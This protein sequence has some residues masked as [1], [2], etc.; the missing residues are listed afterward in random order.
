MTLFFPDLSSYEGGVVLQPGTPAVI[1]KATEGNYYVD[2]YFDGFKAMADAMKIP[3]S[4]YHFLTSWEDPALQ[5]QYYFN[6]AGSIP[7]MLDVETEGTSKPTVDD[8]VAFINALTRAGGRCWGVYFPRWYWGQV[9]GDLGRLEAAG[10]VLVS[11]D[12]SGYSD[13]GSGWQSY[14][15]ATPRIWQY[16]NSQQYA[17]MP[18]D[19]NAFKGTAQELSDLITG[20]LMDLNT[21]ITFSPAVVQMFPE[22]AAE[23]FGTSAPLGTVLGWM[24]ARIAHLVHQVDALKASNGTVD[25]V[26]VADAELAEIKNKL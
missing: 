23:G 11:S 15:G 24:A 22:L 20:N 8:C 1:A 21:P 19:F 17:G 9:G 18:C 2:A 26:A 3:F 7:C 5:A 13:T 6:K 10:A 25:P 16:T 4:G 14:G 12:Y